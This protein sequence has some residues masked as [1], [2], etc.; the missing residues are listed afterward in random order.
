MK[1]KRF[2]NLAMDLLRTTCIFRRNTAHKV[3]SL[4]SYGDSLP[5]VLDSFIS[6]KEPLY[7]ELLSSAADKD[8]SYIKHFHKRVGKVSKWMKQCQEIIEGNKYG[9]LLSHVS[10][11]S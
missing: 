5:S 8:T 2:E 10:E 4:H 3:H 9:Q 11:I 7:Q 6:S 1:A